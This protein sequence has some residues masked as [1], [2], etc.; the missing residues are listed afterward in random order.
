MTRAANRAFDGIVV[1]ERL[2]ALEIDVTLACLVMYAAATWD[3]HRYHYDTRY[4]NER[5]FPAPFVD[6][7]MLG[8]L[9]ARQL[10][11]WGGH[12]AFLRRLRYRLSAMV[13]VGDRIVV[14]GEVAHTRVDSG[15]GLAVCRVEIVKSD[16]TS[17]VSA[18]EGT[19]DFGPMAGEPAA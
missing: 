18:A 2:P 17:V 9:I 12:D 1:G 7:Q 15:H 3:F 4:V 5:G 13:F 11:D 10:M 6:G 8:A 19:V 16:G 14:S